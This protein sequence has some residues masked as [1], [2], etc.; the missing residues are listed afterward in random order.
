MNRRRKAKGHHPIGQQVQG[1]ALAAFRGG[2]TG[3]RDQARFG[4]RIQLGLCAG[5]WPLLQCPQPLF[6]E[7][8]AGGIRPWHSPQRGRQRWRYPASPQSL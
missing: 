5:A 3:F 8:L 1:P 4:L 7:A 2:T 6:D